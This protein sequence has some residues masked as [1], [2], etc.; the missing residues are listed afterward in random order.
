MWARG[1]GEVVG[2]RREA[3]GGGRVVGEGGGRC[4]GQGVW[5]GVGALL[6]LGL[7]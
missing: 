3:R 1:G 6:L 5:E 2:A 7:P 4:E